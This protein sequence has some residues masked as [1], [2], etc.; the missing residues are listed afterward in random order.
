MIVPLRQGQSYCVFHEL[1]VTYSSAVLLTTRCEQDKNGSKMAASM[2]I[3]TL[4][5]ESCVIFTWLKDPKH[6][7]GRNSLDILENLQRHSP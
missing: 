7:N 5:G 4:I 1:Q 3:H 6:N 2:Y